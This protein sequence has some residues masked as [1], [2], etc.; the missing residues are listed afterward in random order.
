MLGKKEERH[1]W[2]AIRVSSLWL[3]MV[4]LVV[5][6]RSCFARLFIAK[7]DVG[8]AR[9]F[10]GVVFVLVVSVTWIVVVVAIVVVVVVSGHAMFEAILIA[11]APVLSPCVR[12]RRG[13]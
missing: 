4:V 6:V 8:H 10:G 7:C 13:C 1:A 12:Y 3:Y 5:T 2:I 11:S 9:S